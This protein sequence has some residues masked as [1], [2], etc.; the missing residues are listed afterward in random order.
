[1]SKKIVI[2]AQ[3]GVTYECYRGYIDHMG[4]RVRRGQRYYMMSEWRDFYYMH[5]ISRKGYGKAIDKRKFVSH[6]V[7]VNPIDC[8]GE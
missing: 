7:P 8:C 3:A 6:F 4:S 1:M 5:S 2:K